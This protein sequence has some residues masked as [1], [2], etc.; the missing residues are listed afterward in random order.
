MFA[1]EQMERAKNMRTDVPL[2]GKEL[3]FDSDLVIVTKTDLKGHI[4]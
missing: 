1:R 3:A 4:T 2:T